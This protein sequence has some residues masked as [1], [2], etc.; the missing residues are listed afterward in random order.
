[1][2]YRSELLSNNTLVY[3][4]HEYN[5]NRELYLGTLGL[6]LDNGISF[7]KPLL[8]ALMLQNKEYEICRRMLSTYYKL[9]E[10][11]KVVNYLDS[12]RQQNALTKKL[13]K[14]DST[15]GAAKRSILKQEINN[16]G[17]SVEESVQ[18]S[19]TSARMTF[20]RYNWLRKLPKNDQL[21]L[22]LTKQKEF[23][24]LTNLLHCSDTDFKIPF[25]L[26]HLYEQKY[27]KD[28]LIYQS[29]QINKKPHIVISLINKY[30]IEYVL[31]RSLLNTDVPLSNSIKI[32]FAETETI[33]TYL[34]YWLDLRTDEGDRMILE[35]I[36]KS[37][38]SDSPIQKLSLGKL[39]DRIRAMTHLSRSNDIVKALHAKLIELADDKLADLKLP[40]D[41]PIAVL[42]DAS[43][44]M[45]VAVNTS[46]IIAAILCKI[47]NAKLNIFNDQDQPISSP[48]SNVREVLQFSEMCKAHRSTAPVASLLPYYKNREVVKTF[49]VVTDE[50]ENTYFNSQTGKMQAGYGYSYYG[51]RI[52]ENPHIYDFATMLKLYRQSVY[53]ANIIIVSFQ[54]G[55]TGWKH[56]MADEIV[57]LI[58]D[59]NIKT[60]VVSRDKPDLT[61]IDKIL[62]ELQLSSSHF[63]AELEKLQ[64]RL[65][66]DMKK[67]EETEMNDSASQFTYTTVGTN[68]TKPTLSGYSVV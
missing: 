24:Y 6:I 36:N 15:I 8:F 41:T 4:Q 42:G 22:L 12:R 47:G 40:I 68:A 35:R 53:K 29:N 60:F 55:T 32:K 1:M 37:T 38:S 59:I 18:L 16:L 10:V 11:I 51:R 3:H 61:R 34:W 21:L 19:L 54:T 45:Q 39:M 62:E 57:R 20:I 65:S 17:Q 33:D 44:S 28:S 14:H 46:S 2:N 5:E 56:Y 50:E 25:A 48:P 63:D 49:I 52:T 7:N 9:D 13:A 27:P 31:L 26:K 43:A 58:P 67:A 30:K 23:R 64:D 66:N